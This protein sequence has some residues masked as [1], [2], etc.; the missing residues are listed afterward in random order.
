MDHSHSNTFLRYSIH[1]VLYGLV[2]NGTMSWLIRSPRINKNRLGLSQIESNRLRQS[3]IDSDRL[4]YTRTDAYRLICEVIVWKGFSGLFKETT[5]SY[6]KKYLNLTNAL[7][8]VAKYVGLNGRNLVAVWLTLV[9]KLYTDF[10]MQKGR[11][12][13]APCWFWVSPK[14]TFLG[15]N[16]WKGQ[17]WRDTVNE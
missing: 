5:T 4:K 10:K 9:G 6:F 3:R 11:G 17:I 1:L 2:Q 15:L 16:A 7:E 8:Y 13:L 12:S 14:S